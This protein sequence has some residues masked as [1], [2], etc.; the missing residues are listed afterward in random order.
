VD[1]LEERKMLGYYH[2]IG[3]LSS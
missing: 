3:L 1:K 2:Y